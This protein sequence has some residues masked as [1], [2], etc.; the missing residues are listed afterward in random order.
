MRSICFLTVEVVAVKDL[1]GLRLQL[2]AG[3]VFVWVCGGERI[4]GGERAVQFE[5]KDGFGCEMGAV[6]CFGC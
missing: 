1:R 3:R 5:A 4:C 6:G 2:E